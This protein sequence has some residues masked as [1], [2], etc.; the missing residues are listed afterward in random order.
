MFNT[1]CL[2]YD[3]PN[4]A[5][6]EFIT[7]LVVVDDNDTPVVAGMARRTVEVYGL[8]DPD[9]ESPAWRFEALRLLHE[10]MRHDLG[11]KGYHDAHAWIPPSL[12]KSF[13]RKLRH[14]FGW[15]Q[16]PWACFCRKTGY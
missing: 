2:P 9:W 1:Q 12:L 10:A 15:K 13:G 14:V 7:R 11:A 16:D 5:D 6:P 8:F 4:L 3:W